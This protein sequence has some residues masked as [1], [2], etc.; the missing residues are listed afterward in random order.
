MKCLHPTQSKAKDWCSIH[1][2]EGESTNEAKECLSAYADFHITR[3]WRLCHI[4]FLH[5]KVVGIMPTHSEGNHSDRLEH[6]R[7]G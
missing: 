4:N 6:R 5:F 3:S 1:V 7:S 2:I